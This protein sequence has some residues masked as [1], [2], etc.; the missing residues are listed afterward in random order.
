M[1]IKVYPGCCGGDKV[2]AT[3]TE[4]VRQAGVKAEVDVV[5]DLA[6]T[7]RDGILSTPALKID[8]RLVASGRSPKVR[9]LVA[10]LT[11]SLM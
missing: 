4:A 5:K 6:Q 2:V 3:V 10:L 7:A 1:V 9:D 11:G 8:G